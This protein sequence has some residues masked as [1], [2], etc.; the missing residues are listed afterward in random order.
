MLAS[1]VSSLFKRSFSRLAATAPAKLEL[2]RVFAVASTLQAAASEAKVQTAWPALR[3]ALVHDLW[4]AGFI[5]PGGEIETLRLTRPL[6]MSNAASLLLVG[7]GSGGPAL[8]ITRNLG[9][10]VTGM[11][12][13]PVLLAAATASVKRAQLAKKVTI[14]AWDPADPAFV[15]N[16]HHHCLALEPFHGSQPEPIL[17][18]LAR[19]LRPGGQYRAGGARSA[20]FR[21]PHRTPL[22]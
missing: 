12:T 20:E 13:D 11:D 4:G 14:K 22:G 2:P 21:R 8:A 7:V 15:V 16:S 17:D 5:F 6:G 18:G 1:R 3:L 10:W 9:A 19:A